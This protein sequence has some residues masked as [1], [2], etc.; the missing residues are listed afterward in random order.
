M[1][2]YSEQLEK[3]ALFA[4][5]T[6]TR[7]KPHVLK[8]IEHIPHGQDAKFLQYCETVGVKAQSLFVYDDDIKDRVLRNAGGLCIANC[9]SIFIKRSCYE[10]FCQ[11]KPLGNYVVSHELGHVASY[12]N[13]TRR[14]FIKRISA[15]VLAGVAGATLPQVSVKEDETFKGTALGMIGIYSSMKMVEFA[16]GRIEE[17]KADAYAQRILPPAEILKALIA[18]YEETAE[19]DGKQT[20]LQTLRKTFNESPKAQA[21][22]PQTR[23]LAWIVMLSDIVDLKYIPLPRAIVYPSLKERAQRIVSDNAKGE[24]AGRG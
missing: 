4:L 2:N 23:D 13:T 18:Y 12:E 6:L 21:A 10:S 9:N 1:E 3:K 22:D 17:F 15:G 8:S 7:F 20:Q 16:F 5:M 19:K 24:S 14:D 11:N